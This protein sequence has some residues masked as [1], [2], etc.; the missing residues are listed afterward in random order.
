MFLSNDA[1]VFEAKFVMPLLESAAPIKCISPF[2]IFA[3]VS[4][5]PELILQISPKKNYLQSTISKLLFII[6][7]VKVFQDILYKVFHVFIVNF[8]IRNWQHYFLS[9]QAS[10]FN[11]IAITTLI[12]LTCNCMRNK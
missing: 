1:F 5:T 10:C 11:F 8:T 2:S 7:F 9:L 3:F 12:F 4:L 6:Y